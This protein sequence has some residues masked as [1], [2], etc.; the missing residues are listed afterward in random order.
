MAFSQSVKRSQV[1]VNCKL[2]ETERPIQWKCIDCSILMCSHCKDK[3]HSQFKNAQDHKIVSREEIGLHKEELDFTNIKCHE[4]VG[5]SSCL[6]CNT[7]EILVC[8]TCIAKLH[9]K[10]DLI[11][12]RDEYKMKV[13][14]LK[15]GQS[16]MQTSNST[17]NAKIGELN[18]L[19][20]AENLKYSNARQDIINHEKTVKEQVEKYFKELINK[21]DQSHQTVLTSVKSD[22]NALSLST[23]QTE[24]KINEVQDFIGIS[25]AT[26]FF[27][28][29]NMMQKSTKIKGPLT[30]P[31]YSSSPKFVPGNITQSHIGSLQDDGNL[32]TETNLSLVINSAYQTELDAI[33]FVSP[34]LDQTLWLSSGTNGMILRVKPEGT[35]LK[36]MS[37]FKIEVCGMAVITS[38]QLLLSV[39]GKTSLQQIN[40]TGELTD[41][42]YDVTPF[43]PRAIHVVRD[44]TVI[45]AAYNYE[46]NRGAVMI[47]NTKGDKEAVYVNDKHNQHLL[48][49]P[50]DITCTNNRNVHVV[51]DIS[52]DRSGEVIVLGQGGHIINKYTGHS[53]INKNTPFKP[54]NIV[55]TPSDKVVVIEL[56]VSILHI[57]NDNGDFISYFNIKEI[58]MK[59]RHSLAINTTGHLYI[60]CTRAVGSQPKGSTLYE[61]KYAGF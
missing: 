50:R 57:L 60:G 40:S 35:K 39:S 14:K 9:K 25:N 33:R 61:I 16:K 37:K 5:Q 29:V 48:E 12:I 6:S 49:C 45:V 13:E 44:N 38:S 54:V 53:I 18:K 34:C 26:D 30:K 42:V 46:L 17:M 52:D 43:F 41:S 10:H 32:S 27:K 56:D 3:V 7:C 19:V 31:S 55:T 21:L 20:S 23:K 11:E 47:M 22:L 2:C 8:P 1:P 4:H 28:D 58:G 59:Y 36:V 24:D 15:K 51:D